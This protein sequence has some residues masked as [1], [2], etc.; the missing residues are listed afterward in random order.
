M[1]QS[2][3]W[4][5]DLWL[6]LLGAS[7]FALGVVWFAEP[8]DLVIGG[9]SGISII[10]KELSHTLFG[11]SIPIALTNVL[12]NVPL[13]FIGIR[14]RGFSFAKRSMLSVVWM[15]LAFWLF[16]LLPNPFAG[17]Q[18]LLLAGIMCGVFAGTGIALVLKASATTGGTDMLASIVKSRFPHF[19]M[20]TLILAIDAC[21]IAAGYF[22]F[23]PIK[24][25]Y[26]II[27]VFVA[28]KVISNLLDGMH[29]AKAAFIFSRRAEEIS[30]EIFRQLHRGNT[31]IPAKGMYRGDPFT[32]LY[33]VVSKKE[34]AL[35]RRIIKEI[36]PNAFIT[37]TDV[38]EA[39][40]EGFAENAESLT[41]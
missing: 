23:G 25:L 31:G 6:I 16:P 19:P 20:A 36:D 4:K 30:Q 32:V 13:F 2:S 3:F 10:V 12:L 5:H 29:F 33:V 37:I 15:S 7:I 1:K 24:T 26:A 27:S 18:D 8:L 40:G 11:F 41:L 28:S 22:L 35:L 14:Q 34:I 38:H 9:F 39:L 17:E 21:I